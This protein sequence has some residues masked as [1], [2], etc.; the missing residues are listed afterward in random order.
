MGKRI[1]ITGKKFGDLIVI[2]YKGVNK[3][4]E[5]QWECLCSCGNRSVT[6]GYRLRN[7]HTKS[8]GCL[9]ANSLGDRSRTHGKSKTPEFVMYYSAMRR[10]KQRGVPFNVTPNDIKI[11]KKC[12]VLGIDLIQGMGIQSNN[13]PS[14]DCIDPKLGY[15]KGNIQVVSWRFNKFKS[16]LTPS[17]LKKIAKWVTK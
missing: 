4:G 5:A 14:L 15:V 10:A 17:E 12:P 7:G 8:C 2:G 16:D 13:T 1:D 3:H 6:V 9:K 11:P